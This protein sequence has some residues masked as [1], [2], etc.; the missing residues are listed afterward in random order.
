MSDVI[1]LGQVCWEKIPEA[2]K[3]FIIAVILMSIFVGILIWLTPQGYGV[4]S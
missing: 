4:N 2:V 1:L 3:G